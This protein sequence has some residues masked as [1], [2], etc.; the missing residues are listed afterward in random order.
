MVIVLALNLLNSNRLLGDSKRTIEGNLPA[1]SFVRAICATLSERPQ[2]GLLM[3]PPPSCLSILYAHSYAPR[4]IA[5][6]AGV[7][8][9]LPRLVREVGK[10]VGNVD[11]REGVGRGGGSIAIPK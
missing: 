9:T 5:G 1:V 10:D 3:S 2:R 7:A 6:V 4:A 8:V 11:R